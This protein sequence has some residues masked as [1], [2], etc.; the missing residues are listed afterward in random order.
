[1]TEIK[2]ELLCDEYNSPG[3]HIQFRDGYAEH[4]LFEWN[5]LNFIQMPVA[6]I[7]PPPDSCLLIENNDEYL[8]LVTLD[9]IEIYRIAEFPVR[10]NRGSKIVIYFNFLKLLKIHWPKRVV[11]LSDSFYVLGDECAINH[12]YVLEFNYLG[13]LVS[14]LFISID[15]ANMIKYGDTAILYTV[16][17]TSSS[18]RWKYYNIQAYPEEIFVKSEHFA[19]GTPPVYPFVYDISVD[20]EYKEKNPRVIIKRPDRLPRAPSD[21]YIAKETIDIIYPHIVIIVGHDKLLSIVYFT[22]NILYLY[23]P[24][25]S[26][27]PDYVIYKFVLPVRGLSVDNMQN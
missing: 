21:A 22:D 5:L 9:M 14:V 2:G 11:L 1:M 25:N 26:Y 20:R 13:E 4:Y 10:V 15:G 17:K 19:G 6:S 8:V 27:R 16:I 12:Y 23:S 24:K 18:C 7:K 3:S